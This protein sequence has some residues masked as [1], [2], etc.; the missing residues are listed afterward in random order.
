MK[1]YF[2]PNRYRLRGG[3]KTLK[4]RY[5]KS[6]LTHGPISAWAS[7]L[8]RPACPVAGPGE[9]A[10]HVE[11]FKVWKFENVESF[12]IWETSQA[13]VVNFVSPQIVLLNTFYESLF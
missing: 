1:V 11:S 9:L 6:S 5:E 12:D 7:S 3:T 4:P 10:K 2:S 13:R 8:A